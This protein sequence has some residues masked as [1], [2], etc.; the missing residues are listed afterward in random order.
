MADFP[1]DPTKVTLE[2]AKEWLRDR[3]KKG[4]RCPCCTQFAKIYRRKLNSQMARGLIVFYQESRFGWVHLHA[5][6][7]EAKEAGGSGGRA[8]M[9]Y[10]GVIEA[11]PTE[12][13]S[14]RMTDLGR[15]FVEGSCRIPKYA[16]L[17]DNRLLKLDDSET[18]D[19]R[20]ALGEHFN[21]AELMRGG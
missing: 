13:G 14:Y 10:W 8:V 5:M 1:F 3:L 21:Y 9:R 16:L 15:A 19:I 6:F 17:Y 18:V 4:E 2:E 20:E 7:T 11:H 12:A